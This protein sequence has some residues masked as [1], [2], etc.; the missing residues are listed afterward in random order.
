MLGD[1]NDRLLA[2]LVGL[3]GPDPG[4]SSSIAL[5]G[6]LFEWLPSQ[7]GAHPALDAA[8]AYT[9]Q[10][11]LS[12]RG[13]DGANK[14][15]VKSGSTALNCLRKAVMTP[16]C[17]MSDAVLMAMIVHTAAEV[18]YDSTHRDFHLLTASECFRGIGS[19]SYV[20]HILALTAIIKQRAIAGKYGL[21]E[22]TLTHT[23]YLEEVSTVR[24]PLKSAH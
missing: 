7:V 13:V 22:M 16:A 2:N 10:G 23:I 21:T 8:I 4:T 19:L 24:A 6:P 17:G 20:F 5:Y 11:H 14:S 9:I 12:F 18:W 3:L 1:G 15:M